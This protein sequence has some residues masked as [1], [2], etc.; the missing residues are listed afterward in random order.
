MVQI[1][2]ITKT[3]VPLCFLAVMALPSTTRAAQT[4]QEENPEQMVVTATKTARSLEDAPGSIEVISAVQIAEMNALSVAEALE[5]ALGLVVSSETGRSRAP[6]I[7]GAKGKHTLV[8]IDGRRIVAGYGEL[9]DINQLP[10]SMVERIEVV[11]GPSSSLYGSD[12]LGGVV[13][14][15]TKKPVAKLQ[16]E[17]TGQYGINQDGEGEEFIGSAWGNAYLGRFSFNGGVQFRGKDIWNRTDNDNLDDGDDLD[18]ASVASRFSFALRDN[19]ILSGGIDFNDGSRTG[20]RLIEGTS[21]LRDADDEHLSGYLQYDVELSDKYQLT[22]LANRSEF[23]ND[24]TL[25]PAANSAEEGAKDYL[26]NQ[27]EGRFTG[28]FFEKHLATVGVELRDE[29]RE[30]NT[31]KE[32]DADNFSV[33]AQDEYQV[34]E[35]LYLVMG[36]RYDEHSEFGSELT[37]KVSLVWDINPHLK[38]KASYGRGFRAP[39]IS[40]LFITSWRQR[41]RV[42]YTANPELNPETSDSYEIGLEGH[43]GP[44]RGGLAL[45][46]NDYQDLIEAEF[47]ESVG[48]GQNRRDYYLLENVARARTQGLELRGDLTLPLGFSLAAS[49]MWLDTENRET[50][51]ELEGQPEFKSDLKLGYHNESL[52]LDANI[53]AAYYGEAYSAAGNESDYALMHGYIA[54]GITE[55]LKIFAGV[56]NLFDEDES[57]P[58]F[59]YSGINVKF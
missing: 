42:I 25:T 13:N 11:R 2:R 17:V 58:T 20:E 38:G 28:L 31:G 35:V 50:G 34:L 30:D 48:S 9:V 36:A 4:N 51:E 3:L 52:R 53:R 23:T 59:F 40:E 1:G 6:S 16:G 39:N 41:G 12:A 18:L 44:F 19:Q 15:I 10:V 32:Y 27:F 22:L 21:R 56:D 24:I 47:V 46:R 55:K 14:I 33:F 43:Y 7:R 54:K 45:F 37:P 8:L 49:A 29:S 5:N 26:L 57:E